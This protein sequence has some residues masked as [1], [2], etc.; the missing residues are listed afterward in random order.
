MQNS[1]GTY[2]NNWSKLKST[3]FSVCVFLVLLNAS[4]VWT[5][6]FEDVYTCYFVPEDIE[7]SQE[8][9]DATEVDSNEKIKIGADSI[10]MILEMK[11]KA[12]MF[13]VPAFDQAIYLDA[14]S[15][16]PWC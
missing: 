12:T 16:P 8:L 1:L 11:K 7:E 15:L 3:I 9:L 4:N 13:F 2:K 14:T 10:A 5:L 6:V